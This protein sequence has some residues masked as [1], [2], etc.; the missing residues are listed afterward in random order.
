MLFRPLLH[1]LGGR[2][3]RQSATPH[4]SL[5]AIRRCEFPLCVVPVR[6]CLV[7]ETVHAMQCDS[8]NLHNLRSSFRF[9]NN[10][11]DRGRMIQQ[12]LHLRTK[13]SLAR[14]GFDINGSQAAS[15]PPTHPPT[16]TGHTQWQ[17]L[18][19]SSGRCC[20]AGLGRNTT[21]CVVVGV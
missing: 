2:S 9:N 11:V 12:V 17:S 6:P 14:I 20:S 5:S 13:A 19:R 4:Q 10:I 15:D 7:G 8:Q 3:S 21:R 18:A 16:R 1:R